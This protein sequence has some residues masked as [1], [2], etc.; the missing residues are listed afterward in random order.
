MKSDSPSRKV[1]R[2]LLDGPPRTRPE[3]AAR[4]GL[5][6]P[7][8]S[9]AVRR[10]EG[11][12]LVSATGV[13]RGQPG[14]VPVYYGVAPAAGFV[15]AVDIGGDNL[16]ACAADLTG[17]ELAARRRATPESGTDA[18][19]RATIQMIT[20]LRSEAGTSHGELRALALSA[21]GVV[22]G[23]G[24][25]VSLAYNLGEEGPFDLVTD[26]EQAVGVPVAVDNNV[27]LAAQ[28]EVWRGHGREVPTFAFVAV[29]AG[30]GMGLV[31]KGELVR[32]AHGA[33]GE[34]AS[35]PLPGRPA[36]I[37]RPVHGRELLAAEA[38]GYRMMARASRLKWEGDAPASVAEIF[39][40][41]ESGD[42]TASGLVRDEG[43]QIGLT[44]ASACAVFDPELVVLGGGVASNPLLLPI[45]TRSARSLVPFPPRIEISGLGD[46]ASL[47]GALSVALSR[48]HADLLDGI[49][50]A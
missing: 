20:R 36:A 31:H 43:R 40:R 32:G 27:N 8:I 10:L 5:S 1:L 11:A 6:K 44:V 22:H 25:T 37:R 33:A 41:A 16:R 24:R 48:A 45:V 15:I 34:V 49:G 47:T 13:R 12:R 50:P 38:G 30:I 19:V 2:V 39:A 21:P 3:L 46:L 26:I 4:T 35:L 17:T 23:D 42:R 18:V 7:T 28:G 14:R 9:G 29:G